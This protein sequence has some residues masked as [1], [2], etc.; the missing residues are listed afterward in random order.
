MLFS[1]G[2]P[3]FSMRKKVPQAKKNSQ[4]KATPAKRKARRRKNKRPTGKSLPRNAKPLGDTLEKHLSKRTVNALGR[5]SRFRQRLPKQLSPWLFLQSA[6][7]LVSLSDISL[8]TWALLIGLLGGGT[9]AAQSLHER[10]GPGAVA[11][12]EKALQALMAAVGQLECAPLEPYLAHFKHVFIHDSTTL[13]LGQKLAGIFAGPKNRYGVSATLKIQSCF[14]LLHQRF[15]HFGLSSFRR[16]DQA[17]AADVLGWLRPGDLILRDLG[18]FVSTVLEEILQRGAYFLSRLRLDMVLYELDGHTEVDLLRRL[19][20]Q[21]FLDEC[22]LLGS[23]K[24]P[25]RVVAVLEAPEVRAERR[26]KAKH[27]RDLRS[28]PTARHLALLD[29][30]IFITNVPREVWSA[31]IVAQVYGIRWRVE[32]IFKAWKS[33]FALGQ[34]DE[35]AS[36]YEVQAL[37]Y[38]KLIFIVL[39]NV[40]FWRPALGRAL[41]AGEQ[42]FPSLLKVSQLMAQW[43]LAL[44]LE[45]LGISM[46]AALSRQIAYHC[47][48]QKR[49]RT[50]FLEEILPAPQG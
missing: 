43:I 6:C 16:N 37:V 38:A 3:L 34:I 44:L 12:L 31:Q 29:W 19:R 22:L 11:F 2:V 33:H 27:N 46:R 39:F 21:G 4:A 1:Q 42:H 9:L 45:E 25:V 10:L 30:S 15:E 47:R 26:R 17:A 8:R 23:R 18:Y 36:Q 40:C 49:R 20:R 35:K 41:A 50:H 48:Y 14:D 5:S 24:V 32:T 7:V 28:V 13:S